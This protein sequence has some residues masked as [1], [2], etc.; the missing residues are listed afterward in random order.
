MTTA[1][2]HL[3]ITTLPLVLLDR[4]EYMVQVTIYPGGQRGAWLTD[5]AGR[6]FELRGFTDEESAGI[7][8]VICCESGLPVHD[9]RPEVD[10]DLTVF[11]VGDVIE[12]E[13]GSED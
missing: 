1:L 10:D 5:P 13:V 11:F 3:P 8:Q 7:Y 9:D 6:R 12:L 4:T 2:P